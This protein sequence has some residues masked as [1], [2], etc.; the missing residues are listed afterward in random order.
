MNYLIHQTASTPGWDFAWDSPIW[1]QAETASVD[2]PAAPLQASVP[3]TQVRILHDNAFLYGIFRIQDHSIL[4]R[5]TQYNSWTCFDSCVEFFFRPK[6]DG[7]YFNL[8]ISATGAHLLYYVH[9]WTPVGDYYADFIA[10]PE[11]DGRLFETR[12]SLTKL[13][14]QERHGDIT[15]L[16]QFKVPLAIAEKYCGS[17]G[18]L[19]GQHWTGNFYKCGDQLMPPHWLAWSPVSTLNFHLPECFGNFFIE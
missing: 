3:I 12:S 15:W 6:Q 18:T 4:A 10:I 8:E 5:Q 16:V 7:G 19:S 17:I 11:A 1:A 14:P 2:H 13:V 9:D